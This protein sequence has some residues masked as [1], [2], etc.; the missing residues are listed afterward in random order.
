MARPHQQATGHRAGPGGDTEEVAGDVL[1]VGVGRMVCART[2]TYLN[3]SAIDTEA[4][5]DTMPGLEELLVLGAELGRVWDDGIIGIAV[6]V[7]AV[8]N[9]WSS[10]SA[11]VHACGGGGWRRRGERSRA[12]AAP[13]RAWGGARG[14]SSATD[15]CGR[16]RR[17]GSGG[18]RGCEGA[19]GNVRF[20][21]L[22]SLRTRDERVA[23][24]SRSTG[25]CRGPPGRAS[26][27]VL[28]GPRCSCSGR[29]R[30]SQPEAKRA[31]ASR[32]G[33]MR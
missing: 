11:W 9:D 8:D 29:T 5:V 17:G 4:L 3:L 30:R 28:A 18:R 19:A 25:A 16:H 24:V 15:A 1:S 26:R 7:A 10:Q 32:C 27:V 33:P 22:A 23:I 2:G 14:L 20:S 21:L 31:A 6:Q 13:K 12:V